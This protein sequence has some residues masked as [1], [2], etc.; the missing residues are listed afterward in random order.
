MNIKL[1]VVA[2][3]IFKPLPLPSKE[4]K[5]VGER[6]E[7][8]FKPRNIYAGQTLEL[9]GEPELERGHYRV[10]LGGSDYLGQS[11]GYL[12]RNHVRIE[13]PPGFIK[14]SVKLEVP[15]V[16]QVPRGNQPGSRYNPG[17]SCNVAS[18]AMTLAY[19]G[20]TPANPG[21]PLIDSLYS[22]M[23]DNGYSR[24]SPYDLAAV[25]GMAGRGGRLGVGN[26]RVRSD[27]TTDA[28][29]DGVRR[30][31]SQGHPCILHG[32]FTSFGH[33]IVAVGYDEK[34]LIVHDPYGEWFSTG[35][36]TDL[37]GAY[38]YYS[39]EL[40]RRTCIPDGSFWV[41]FVQLRG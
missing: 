32:Y 28:D 12:Y 19:Y 9:A 34:G 36:R 11:E 1:K 23:L 14:P 15:Y 27:F 13:Y 37:C 7:L 10:N 8:N 25:I 41:H 6:N 3:S 5:A 33:I 18:V 38:L 24:H 30:H 26:T 29:L 2:D 20:I 22:W 21:Y 16:S 35:Y 40:I 39:Y 17:G 4:L 31:L